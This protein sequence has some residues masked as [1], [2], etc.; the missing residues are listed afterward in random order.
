MIDRGEKM[1][2]KNLIRITRH[3]AIRSALPHYPS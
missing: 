3:P 1:K 2:I